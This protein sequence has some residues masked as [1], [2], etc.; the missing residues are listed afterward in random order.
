MK[1]ETTEADP[2]IRL[3]SRALIMIILV[4]LMDL[5]PLQ[6]NFTLAGVLL[7]LFLGALDQTIVATALPKIVQNL[8]GL[9]RYTWVATAYLLATTIMV[10]IYGK[11]ADTLNR[12]SVE[13]TAVSLFLAGSF[14][15]GLSG[16]L[17]FLSFLGDGM[18]QLI[19]FRVIQGLGGAGLFALAFIVIADLFPPAERGRYQG[20]VGA[21]FGLASVLGPLAGGFLTDHAGGLIPGIEGWHWVF[22][23]NL[24]F[25]ALALWFIS[26][27]MPPLHPPAQ[28]APLDYLSMALLVAGFLPLVLALQLDKARFPWSSP[29]TLGLLAGSALLLAL[30]ALSA[31]R[32]S[33]P[34]LEMRLFRNRVYATSIPA[35]FFIGAGFLSLVVFLPLF[36]I[37]VVGVSATRAGVSLIPVSIGLVLG[38]A[39]AG[40]AVSR[41]GHYKLQ[42]LG[43]GALLAVGL[44][45]LSRMTVHTSYWQVT[46]YMLVCG[47]GLGP[48]FPLYT[49]AVQNAMEP[50]YI[51]QATGSSIFFRQIGGTVGVAIMGT[52]LAGVLAASFARLPAFAA[53]QVKAGDPPALPRSL[54]SGSPEELAAAIHADFDRQY[55]LAERAL[56]SRDLSAFYQLMDERSFPT[57]ARKRLITGA[58]AGGAGAE[59]ALKAI[60]GLLEQQANRTAAAATMAVRSAFARAVT[61]IFFYAIFAV[62]AAIAITLFIPELPLRRTHARTAEGQS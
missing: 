60:R 9:D 34:V 19:L 4:R 29:W 52:V 31:L 18:S 22:Y 11:L 27:W 40:Q 41:F 44:F 55:A 28:K 20:L 3:C 21:V 24:P 32:S 53:T 36:M 54:G 17:P 33:N 25:G 59:Q 58:L 61:R 51:G 47:L 56:R 57:A 39:L 48:T 10:P 12:K 8:Q 2:E 14:L 5:T 49:L 45:L 43:G 26:A 35:L 15:C 50:R 7:A 42:I 23:V 16:E 13:L 46:L 38:S 6:K 1:A 30:F 62:L 37:N